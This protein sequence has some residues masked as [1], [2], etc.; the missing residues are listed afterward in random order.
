MIH[1]SRT[2]SQSASSRLW[3]RLIAVFDRLVALIGWALLLLGAFLV[4][5]GRPD[6]LSWLLVGTVLLQGD[7]GVMTRLRVARLEQ[8]ARDR[9]RESRPR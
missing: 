4:A 9:Q 6:S 8:W 1:R 7:D 3:D 2:A 5:T